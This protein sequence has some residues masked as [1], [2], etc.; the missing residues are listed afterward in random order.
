MANQNVFD[1]DLQL[2][3]N[4]RKGEWFLSK[5]RKLVGKATNPTPIYFQFLCKHLITNLDWCTHVFADQTTTMFDHK[6]LIMLVEGFN[7]STYTSIIN[8]L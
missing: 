8:T 3:L 5:R 1:G 2:S 4:G 6:T 7:V